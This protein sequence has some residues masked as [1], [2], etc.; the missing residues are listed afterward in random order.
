MNDMVCAFMQIALEDGIFQLQQRE[1]LFVII[2]FHQSRS[3]P[4]LGHILRTTKPR[5]PPYILVWENNASQSSNTHGGSQK[6]MGERWTYRWLLYGC[7]YCHSISRRWSDNQHC[8][9]GGYHILC[10]NW[11]YPTL[12][13][14]ILHKNVILGFGKE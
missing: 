5:R 11:Q 14:P 13:M 6:Q 12:H 1:A 3:S 8:F 4:S 9:Q 7:S 2:C 10:H